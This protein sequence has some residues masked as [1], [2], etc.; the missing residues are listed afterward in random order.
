MK[1]PLGKE[2][3]QD[4]IFLIIQLKKAIKVNYEE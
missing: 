2:P 3:I 1:S 4:K